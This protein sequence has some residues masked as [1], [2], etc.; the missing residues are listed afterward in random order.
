ML[1]MGASVRD[2]KAY[3]GDVEL[4]DAALGRAAGVDR[5]V[6]RSAIDKISNDPKLRDFFAGLRSIALLADV[7]DQIGCSTLTIIPTNASIPGILADVS[8]VTFA[9]GI[10]IRQAVIDDPDGKSAKLLIV[11]DGTLPHEFIPALQKCRGVA[12]IILK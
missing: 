5:R 12:S 7:A 3:C 10:S 6:A 9:A 4:S 11:L 2:G 1:H 8:A